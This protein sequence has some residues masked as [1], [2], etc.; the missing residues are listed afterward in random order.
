M[1]PVLRFEN[2]GKSYG[3]NPVLR[4]VTLD[5]EP[6]SVTVLIGAS[7]S[8]KS[9]L[10]RCANG[11]EPIAS[12]R[13]L[14]KGEP[15]PQREAD[16]RKVREQIGFVFQ[17]FNLFPHLTALGNVAL[18]T[19]V[20]R[21]LPKGEAEARAASLLERVGLSHRVGA[22][23]AELSGGQQQRVSIARALAMEPA[24]LMFDEP[25]SALDPELTGEVVNVMLEL[26]ASGMTMLVVSHEMGFVRRAASSV[27][28][29]A[30][31][32]I[33]DEGPWE[34]LVE[35]PRDPRMHKFLKAIE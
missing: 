15:L 3:A 28:F 26:A 8:G 21:K 23:P 7:G 30:D 13:V 17:S 29:M 12:G 22:Y 6:G 31:G 18:A 33:V 24:F 16:L 4:D 34:R 25:T 19:R 14:F 11:L 1:A 20:V 27:V 9:T 35:A 32:A 5:V 10:L 2:V